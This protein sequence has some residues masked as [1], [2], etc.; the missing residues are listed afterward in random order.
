MKP[1]NAEGPLEVD[2]SS[3][4]RKVRL[5]ALL[6]TAEKAGLT[7]LPINRLHKLAY[8]SNVLA[9]VWDM[10]A[11]DG[12]VLKRQ[13]GPFY[14][15]LQR[16]LDLLV[17]TGVV[18]VSGVGHVLDEEKQ[19]K[20]DGFYR[21]NRDLADRILTHVRSFEDER[22]LLGFLQEL[23]FALAAL[24]D[25][26][27]NKVLVEDATYSDPMIDFGNIVDFAEWQ[28]K[29]YTA[30]A[31]RYFEWLLPEGSRATPS[32]QLHLYVRHLHSRMH[33]QR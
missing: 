13:G 16:D 8:F 31:A 33:G 6:D 15:S 21:L 7:P 25:V 18:V 1:K 4:R 11:L 30:S 10:L 9:P 5:I 3:L 26:D 22:R 2:V 14:P 32:E 19:W 20:L 27:L 23:A 17:G 24:S 29:N 12:K 28:Q